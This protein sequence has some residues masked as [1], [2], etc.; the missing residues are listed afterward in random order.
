MSVTQRAR[1]DIEKR[2]GLALG[3]LCDAITAWIYNKIADLRK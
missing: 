1:I 3:T 2:N